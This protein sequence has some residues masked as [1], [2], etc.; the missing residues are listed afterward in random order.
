MKSIP[1]NLQEKFEF[2]GSLCVDQSSLH[3]HQDDGRPHSLLTWT[4]EVLT[5]RWHGQRNTSLRAALEDW[6]ESARNSSVT[7]RWPGQWVTSLRADQDQES[8]KICAWTHR[9]GTSLHPT[10]KLYQV[11]LNFWLHQKLPNFVRHFCDSL[12]SNLAVSSPQ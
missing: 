4:T 9:F 12:S 8:Q 2:L 1:L 10:I 3:I 5:R 7:P 6:W 11:L